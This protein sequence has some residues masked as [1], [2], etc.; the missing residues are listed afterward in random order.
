MIQFLADG[1]DQ[2]DIALDQL[3]VRD[4]NF[5]RFALMLVDNITELTLHRYAQDRAGENELW[6][7]L[8]K[9]KYD[10]KPIANALGQNFENKVK[11]AAKLKL[12]NNATC[13]SILNLHAFRNTAYHRGLRHEGI[14]HSLTL[15][16]FTVVCEL[17]TAYEPRFWSWSSSDVLSHRARKYLGDIHRGTPQNDFR[18]AYT[19]L[20][21]VAASMKPSLV[22]DLSIDMAA[23]IEQGDNV[24]EFLSVDSP[25]P[26][27][28]DRAVI[29]SQAWA[30]AF[31]DEGKAF[32]ATK[33]CLEKTVA[34]Y[35]NWL[36][37]EYPW[38]FKRD[39]IPSWRLRVASLEKESDP[40]RAL[41]KYC[42][43]MRQ[44]ERFRA[45]LDESAAQLDGFIEEQIDIARGK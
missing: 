9:P 6:T 17:L 37:A 22:T 19:R 31:T 2:L 8:Q 15:F 28:R 45:V 4:R 21:E 44:T 33:G 23:T 12:I 13:E 32:A 40:H 27:S 1:I 5:D 25:E 20:S 29:L 14:L 34:G 36:A 26:V 39:P 24:I 41:K 3:A 16:Y 43:F 38:P 42:D 11:L 10:P 35:V 18:A 30:T 7:R